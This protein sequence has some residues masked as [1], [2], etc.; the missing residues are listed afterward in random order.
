M[1]TAI[2]LVCALTCIIHLIETSTYSLRIAGVNTKK[3]ATA[4]SLITSILMVS[5]LSNLFQAP[6]LGFMVDESILSNTSNSIHLLVQQFRWVVFS[7]FVGSLIG[8]I[9]TPIFVESHMFIIHKLSQGKFLLHAVGNLFIPQ[10]NH[11]FFSHL[12]FLFFCL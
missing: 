8:G 5:R 11:P 3:I 6:I 7:A 1:N 12:F 4:L 2:V 9:L 10:K